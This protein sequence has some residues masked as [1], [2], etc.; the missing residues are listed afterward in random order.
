M[1]CVEMGKTLEIEISMG[2]Q[3]AVTAER[4]LL[5]AAHAPQNAVTRS[6]WGRLIARSPAKN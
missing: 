1:Q 2:C 4:Q 3:V 5:V 6:R